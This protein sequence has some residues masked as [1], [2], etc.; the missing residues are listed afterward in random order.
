MDAMLSQTNG[1]KRDNSWLYLLM[2]IETV[3]IVVRH[4]SMPDWFDQGYHT[5]DLIGKGIVWITEICLP[6]FFILCGYVFFRGID[7]IPKPAWFAQRYKS[8]LLSLVIPYLIAN[9]LSLAV[10]L[11]AYKFAPSAM[12]GFMGDNWKDPLFIFWKGPVNLSLWFLR[13]LFIIC[14]LSP[15]I[16]LL[17][18]YT[19]GI[20]VIA[21]GLLWGFHLVPEPLFWFTLGATPAILCLHSRRFETWMARHPVRIAADCP[22]WCFFIY[23]Y[24]Y[25]PQIAMKKVG[26][27]L[28][29]EINSAGLLAVWICNA[30]I[31]LGGLSLIYVL[32]RRF[33]PKLLSVLA[34]GS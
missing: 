4:A 3:I 15:L 30:L 20:G 2:V 29:P 1:V 14:L 28:L 6:L 27:A 22:R 25:L 24:H 23:L 8:V 34:G 7:K 18:R 31:L 10:Y 17:V 11:L 26:V 13:E 19:W 21:V 32:L 16:Y 12:S 33:T 9:I 5:F